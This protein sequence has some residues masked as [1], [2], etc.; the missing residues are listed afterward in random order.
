MLRMV[1]GVVSIVCESFGQHVVV[2]VVVGIGV[3]AVVISV[4]IVMIAVVSW[5]CHLLS[6]ASLPSFVAAWYTGLTVGVG[7]VLP[8]SVASWSVLKDG[9][10]VDFPLSILVG[11]LDNRCAFVQTELLAV[12]P[13]FRQDGNES[14]MFPQSLSCDFTVVVLAKDEPVRSTVTDKLGVGV[15]NE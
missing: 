4:R 9:P 2:V 3:I 15:F 13:L 6:L 10:F 11:S 1:V 5:T 14:Y 7:I 8:F 12:E